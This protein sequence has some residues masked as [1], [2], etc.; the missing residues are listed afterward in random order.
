[1]E[2]KNEGDGR[3]ETIQSNLCEKLHLT[4]EFSNEMRINSMRDERK[5]QKHAWELILIAKQ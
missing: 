1:M 3:L 4:L 2:L 5:Q